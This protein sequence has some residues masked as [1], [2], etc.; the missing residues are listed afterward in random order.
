VNS[1]QRLGEEGFLA[2]FSGRDVD[3]FF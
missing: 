2:E 1:V 3:Y